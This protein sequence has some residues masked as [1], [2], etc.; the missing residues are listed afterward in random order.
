LF[1]TRA[2]PLRNSDGKINKWLGSNTDIDRIRKAEAQLRNYNKDLENRVIHR[3]NQLEVA[4]KELEAF[5][6]SVSHDLRAPLRSVHGYAKILM[7]EYGNKLDKEG[8]RLCGIITSSATQMGELI[9]DLLSFSRI[10]RSNVTMS[11]LDM[12]KLASQAYA[13]ITAPMEKDRISLELG[14]LHEASGDI[15]LIRLVWNNLIS[16]AIKYSSKNSSSEIKISSRLED[17]MIQYTVKDNGVGFDMQYKHK[18]FG[19]FQRLHSENEFEGN[20]V[21]LAIVQRIISKHGG[22]VWAEAE[23]G[24]GAEFFFSLPAQN[25]NKA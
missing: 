16:N 9:D 7:E 17:G 8:K 18:L 14:K 23:S 10:G 2:V 19:V 6:Y 4:N 21:G 5:S 12:N 13:E 1:Q 15:K 22:Y 25:N 11:V 3:T 24:K 20:G